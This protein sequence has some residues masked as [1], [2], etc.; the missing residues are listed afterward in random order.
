MKVAD[1]RR[2]S[3]G[4]K[5]SVCATVIWEDSDRPQKEI[6]IE[7]SAQFSAD[8]HPD[9]NAFLLATIMPALRHGESRLLVEGR[10]CPKLRNGLD[11]A[12]QQI[13]QWQGKPLQPRVRIEA[14]DGFYSPDTGPPLRTASFMSGGVDAL[15]MLRTNRNDFALSHPASIRD[16]FFVHGMDVGGYEEMDS[17]EGNSKTAL[18]ALARLA[19]CTDFTLIPVNTNIRHLDDDDNFFYL[20]FYGSL[21]GAV[22]H[23]FSGRITTAMVAAG[24]SVRDLGPIGSHPLLDPNYGS[25][26][27][28]VEHDGVRFE[29]IEKIRILSTWKEGLQ[30]L[31]SCFHP[32]REAQALNCG[33]CEKCIRVMTALLIHGVLDQAPTYPYDD[34][35]PELINSIYAVTPPIKEGL[36][37]EDLVDMATRTL[38]P[39]NVFYWEEMIEPLR[40][41]G[42]QDLAEPVEQL[43]KRYRRSTKPLGPWQ[44]SS[45]RSA[46]GKLDSRLLGGRVRQIYRSL[47]G[48]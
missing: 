41:M 33:H 26:W 12:M 30:S 22:A 25:Y 1:L 45:L 43:V 2:E 9:P 4:D 23:A 6:F 10:L 35:K 11:Y 42:R 21:M 15:S 48:E 17:N 24:S 7:T 46:I 37:R 36:A 29:R 34:V 39:S 28:N 19:D 27:L 18:A 32:F 14:G 47:K 13:L 44:R 20:S 5:V 31:R 16:C 3:S 38:G 8:I 40:A